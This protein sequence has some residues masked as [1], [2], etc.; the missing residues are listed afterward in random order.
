MT[1]TREEV[2][3]GAQ[4]DAPGEIGM[5]LERGK[6][7]SAGLVL[8]PWLEAQRSDLERRLPRL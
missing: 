7:I 5:C 4:V 3:I 8:P 6:R 1:R 2:S